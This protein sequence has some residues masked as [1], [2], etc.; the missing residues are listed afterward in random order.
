VVECYSDADNVVIAAPRTIISQLFQIQQGAFGNTECLT[1]ESGAY[2]CQIGNHKMDF[3][4]VSGITGVYIKSGCHSIEIGNSQ[5]ALIPATSNCTL[6]K[7]RG[8][9]NTINAQCSNAVGA[10]SVGFDLTGD[11][12]RIN[13]NGFNCVTHLLYGGGTNNTVMMQCYGG[14][15]ITGTPSSKDIFMITS[16][17]GSTFSIPNFSCSSPHDGT[18]IFKLSFNGATPIVKPTV[19]GSKGGNAAL[20]SLVTALANLGLITDTTT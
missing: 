3:A 19:T 12:N 17:Q 9:F 5:A 10:A 6:Y 1:F 4:S 13:A 2:S 11:F 16:D 18:N 14:I 15:P 20:G 8:N 7:I